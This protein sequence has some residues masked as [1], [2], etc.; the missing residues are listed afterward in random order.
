MNHVGYPLHVIH[1]YRVPASEAIDFSRFVA[2][3][4]HSTL[5]RTPGLSRQRVAVLPYAALLLRRLLEVSG[6]RDLV[7]CAYG[8]REGC[9]YD[10]L[11]SSRRRADPLIEACQDVARRSGRLTADGEALFEWTSPVFDDESAGQRRLRLAACHLADLAWSEH[12]DYRAEQALLRI[13]RMPLVGIDHPGRA[14]IALSV[15]SRH[16]VV[17]QTMRERYIGGLLNEAEIE[18]ARATGLAM[19]LGYTV[20]GGVLSLLTQTA[21]RREDAGLVL[22]L[23]DHADILVGD[24]VERRFRSLARVLD[25]EASIAYEGSSAKAIA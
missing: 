11:S 14:Y 19:R 15:A 24:V 12:P 2:E 21:I 6:A 23:P 8:L 13:L 3:L 10:R 16:A 22:V 7:F 25:C 20:S 1:G 18:R 5:S 9:L 4:S 17:R